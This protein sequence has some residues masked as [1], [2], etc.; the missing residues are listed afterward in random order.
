MISIIQQSREGNLCFIPGGDEVTNPSELIANG[1]MKVL[2]DRLTP[3][4][5]WIILDSPPCLLVSDASMLADLCDGVLLVTRAGVT[6]STTA[7]R[8]C[9]ELRGRN[10]VGVVLN[11][12]QDSHQY[13]SDYYYDGYSYGASPRPTT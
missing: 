3:I 9:Q 8:A 1:R 2:L 11:A 10:V 6:P 7:Q 13:H 12:M 5:D 4:F